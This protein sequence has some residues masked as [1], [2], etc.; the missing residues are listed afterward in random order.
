MSIIK[1]EN[2]LEIE[3]LLDE[4]LDL[5]AEERTAW[6][7]KLRTTAPDLAEKLSALLSLETVADQ[8]GFL[9]DPPEVPFA[10]HGLEGLQLGA[11]TLER[12]LG[13]GG[14]GSVWLARRA[15]GRFEGRVAVK[16]LNLASL[17]ASGQERFRREGSLLARLTHP[18]IA[19]LIDAGVT[20]G[21]QP[22]LVLEYVEGQPID[23]FVRGRA[24]P[25]EELLRL[26][27]QVLAAVAHA[28][29]NLVVHRDLKPSN[30][31]VSADGEVKLLDFGIAKL[32]DSEAGHERTALT[33]EGGR[34]L[35]PEFASPEQ[36]RGDPITTATDV[37]AL[38][39]LLYILLSARHPTAEGCRS[40]EEVFRALYEKEPARLGLGDLDTI[41]SKALRKTPEERYQTVGALADDVERYL[42]H[43]PVAARPR[44]M[45]YRARKFVRRN[46]AA[47]L[48]A[49]LTAAALLGATGFS[50][51]QAQEAQKQ[52]NAAL[53]EKKRAE[54]HLEFQHLMLSN[55]G[56]ERTSMQ[57]ILERGQELLEREYMGDAHV[58]ATIAL[59]LSYR[60][61]ELAQY[62]REEELLNRA[63]E[64][65]SKAGS[66][67]LLLQIRCSRGINLKHRN[68]HDEALALFDSIQSELPAT[69]SDYVAVCLTL[70]A[71]AQ[72]G[73]GNFERG[74]TL[75]RQSAVMFESLGT[76]TGIAY[77]GVLNA[78]ANAL[79]N[80]KR[81]R[82]AVAIYQR[83]S[84]L[85]DSAGRGQSVTRVV[86]LN[87]IGIALSNLGEMRQ[88][89]PILRE[90]VEM[91]RRSNPAGDVHPAILVNYCR[92]ML[93]LRQ[94]DSA[95]TWYER[96]ATQA[97]ARGDPDFEEMGAFGMAE[98]ELLRGRLPE[99]TRWIARQK[100]VNAKRRQPS[101]MNGPTLDGALAQARGTYA[102]AL[103]SLQQALK[104]AGYD[105]GKRTY[106]MRAILIYAAES[107]LAAQDPKVALEYA[108][109]ARGIAFSDSLSETR[110]AYVGEARLLE[111]RAQLAL[112]DSAAARATITAALNALRAGAGADHPR[113]R[114]AE[115]VLA[116]LPR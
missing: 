24:L 90:A 40:P 99:A 50:V 39:V 57:E 23:A 91:F 108:Q 33:L 101:P 12:L 98:V 62:G 13:A 84:A 36:A 109:A 73:A 66:E 72:N 85:M 77:F 29:A 106:Q 7:E 65:A 56:S 31:L 46:R 80:L 44:A 113:A 94:L 30:I 28:H 35:T 64:F 110:S 18:S 100:S 54:A 15:D 87:N 97:A 34:A 41:L 3:P 11:Y 76:T 69:P 27:L 14:M 71:E 9:A 63:Q 10:S 102:A 19:R 59:D 2:W 5:P 48:A 22:Y 115:K 79:E 104:A 20:S 70:H 42:R 38:G 6:L 4:V 53:L 32:V 111:G 51:R 1:R 114:E 25:R 95:A 88:A 82:E 21:G 93:F 43:E 74:A 68:R 8:R 58:A 89:E 47:V 49:A 96:L 116:G 67:G 26:F 78:E 37:Y 52:R 75:A 60:Y 61:A 55:I 103:T 17:S 107:A 105:E 92:T 112:G 83:M 81:R 86:M 45:L 16:F